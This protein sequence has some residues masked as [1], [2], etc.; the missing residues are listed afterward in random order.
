VGH[1]VRAPGAGRSRSPWRL[2]AGALV[3]VVLLVAAGCQTSS[4]SSPSG[5]G[6]SATELRAYVNQI[7]AV[8]LPVNDLLED[9]DPILD[10]YH[11]K[12]ITPA[13][14]STRMSALE[15]RFAGYLLTVNAIEP[16]NAVLAKLHAPYAHTYFYEDNYLSA[17]ASDLNEGEFDDLPNTQN[18]QRLAIIE[19]RTQL[20]ILA[21]KTGVGLPTDIQQAGRGEIAPAPEGG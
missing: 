18:A 9:A 17:L 20:E 8:R 19:W 3:A 15:Q 6:V 12:T 10:A 7:E 11:D 21:R 14:A 13:Q 5:A 16:S 2:S 4:S 1:R